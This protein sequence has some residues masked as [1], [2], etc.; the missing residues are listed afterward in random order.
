MKWD[1]T[2]RQGEKKP[3]QD[4]DSKISILLSAVQTFTNLFVAPAIL[5]PYGAFT[6]SRERC[7]WEGHM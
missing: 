5:S 6:K 3:G 1:F 7:C 2:H 4:L